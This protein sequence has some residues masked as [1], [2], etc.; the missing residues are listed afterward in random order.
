MHHTTFHTPKPPA[1]DRRSANHPTCPTPEHLCSATCPTYPPYQLH[2][3]CML[4]GAQLMKKYGINV[5]DGI[6]VSSVEEVEKAAKQMADENGEVSLMHASLWPTWLSQLQLS[7]QS[8]P[9]PVLYACMAVV[10]HSTDHCCGCRPALHP[11]TH[12]HTQRVNVAA[13]SSY[14]HLHV[15]CCRLSSRVRSWLA[16][17]A[18]AHSPMV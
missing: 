4:Q 13:N 9:P 5:P 15:L 18:W 3:T 6:A 8:C 14:W 16:A 2:V 10:S 11:M 17:V 1:W 7:H 12:A